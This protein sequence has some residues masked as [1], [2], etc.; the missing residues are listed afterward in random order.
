MC[1]GMKYGPNMEGKMDEFEYT[2]EHTGEVAHFAY[3]DAKD[4]DWWAMLPGNQ[5]YGIKSLNREGCTAFL[6]RYFRQQGIKHFRLTFR[7]NNPTEATLKAWCK[8]WSKRVEQGY[9]E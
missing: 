6:E 5:F 2:S 9:V 4:A 1:Q 3:C 7:P 8:K